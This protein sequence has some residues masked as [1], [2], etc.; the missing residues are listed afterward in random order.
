[1][2][3]RGRG[4]KIVNIASL[5]SEMARATVAPYT[6]AKGGIKMHTVID[7]DGYLP[8]VV[9]VTEA[10]CH[11]VNIA[12]L[13]KLPQG[14]IV[15]FDRGYNDYTWFRHLC[16]SGVFLVTRLKSNARFRVIERHRTDQATEIGR[17]HV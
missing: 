16:K 14:S 2:I 4:G 12:K 6:V 13:L 8:A 10:K 11:E 3:A 17:A 15:V 1:M 5:T 7:H 9:T